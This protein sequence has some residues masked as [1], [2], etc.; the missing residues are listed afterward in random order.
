VAGL[1]IPTYCRL[2]ETGMKNFFVKTNM[3]NDYMA[4]RAEAE[5]YEIK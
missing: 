5:K 1:D 3:Y 4:L 2:A